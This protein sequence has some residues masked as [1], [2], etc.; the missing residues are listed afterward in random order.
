V[1][2]LLQLHD[3][4]GVCS[5]GVLTAATRDVSGFSKPLL[6]RQEWGECVQTPSVRSRAV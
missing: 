6:V 1:R 4:G 2:R 5:D 3:H